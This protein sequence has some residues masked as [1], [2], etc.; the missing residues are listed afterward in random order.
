MFFFYTDKDRSL[1]RCLSPDK[2]LLSNEAMS[3]IIHLKKL[4]NLNNKKNVLNE[5]EARNITTA[6]KAVF[7]LLF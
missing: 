3:N 4:A 7:Q 6:D 1:R 2:D 5:K